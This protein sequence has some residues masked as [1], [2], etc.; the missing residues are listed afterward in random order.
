M[1]RV[2]V[3][4]I[5]LGFF[6][7]GGLVYGVLLGVGVE[8]QKAGVWAQAVLVGGLILW[9]CSYIFRVLT[10]DMTYH[11]QIKDYEEAL[12]Q[13]R[14]ESLTPAERERLQAEVEAERSAKTP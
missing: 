8:S 6:L 2:D 11:Q 14:W 13:K 1:R 4:A 9:L 7:A 12:I 10:H 3:L 5:G